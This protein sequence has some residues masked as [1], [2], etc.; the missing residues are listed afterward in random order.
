M[1]PRNIGLQNPPAMSSA[2]HT[3]ALN[4]DTHSGIIHV[5]ATVPGF[6]ATILDV[7][8]VWGV[9]ASNRCIGGYCGR[10]KVDGDHER[11]R[12]GDASAH[13]GA[14]GHGINRAVG[15]HADEWAGMQRGA[16]GVRSAHRDRHRRR[17]GRS[18]KQMHAQD[19][20]AGREHSLEEA[21]PADAQHRGILLNRREQGG[22]PGQWFQVDDQVNAPG[23]AGINIRQHWLRLTGGGRG[24]AKRLRSDAERS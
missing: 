15:V 18:G 10:V 13:L 3:H 2:V 22:R 4:V 21:A 19:E 14:M 1:I 7:F 6:R 16:V 24:P 9:Y 23:E 11:R 5:E 20:R 12:G 17:A 8:D